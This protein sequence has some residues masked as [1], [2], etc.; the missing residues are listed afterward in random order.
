MHVSDLLERA[1]SLTRSHALQGYRPYPHHLSFQG[2]QG[3]NYKL[4]MLAR[5]PRQSAALYDFMAGSVDVL[6]HFAMGFG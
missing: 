5:G 2:S 3:N 6:Q 1:I 4:N